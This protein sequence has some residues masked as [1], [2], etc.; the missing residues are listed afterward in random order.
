MWQSERQQCAVIQRLLAPHPAIAGLWTSTGP[1]KLACAYLK[2]G[3]PLSSGEMLLLRVA[4]DIWNGDG[5]ARLDELL[6]TLD[7][8]NLHAVTEALLARDAT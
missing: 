3:A 8:R 7:E 2:H 1:T 4:F 6:A 5:K